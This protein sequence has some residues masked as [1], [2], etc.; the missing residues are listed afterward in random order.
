MKPQEPVEEEEDVPLFMTRVP[1]G[2]NDALDAIAALIDEEMDG[3]EPS[4]GSWRK[5]SSLG[6]AQVALSLSGLG[7]AGASTKRQRI[8]QVH[9]S[10][11]LQMLQT[12]VPESLV[13]KPIDPDAAF[14]GG[15]IFGPPPSAVKG[16]V[17]TLLQLQQLN[18]GERLTDAPPLPV[19]CLLCHEAEKTARL[20]GCSGPISR[21]GCPLLICNAC[22]S[23]LMR[24]RS[25][26]RCDACSEREAA[27]RDSD[28]S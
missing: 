13:S 22:N 5:R 7:D 18:R 19:S 11:Q 10:K 28:G 3:T 1:H 25:R 4:S 24:K 27:A 9:D 6:A 8:D 16:P 15:S 20:P 12:L 14:G 26:A 23:S 17:K 21:G 2:K